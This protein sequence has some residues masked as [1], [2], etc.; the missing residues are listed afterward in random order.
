M[1]AVF[2]AAEKEAA[3]TKKV[4]NNLENAFSTFESETTQVVS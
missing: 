3:E 2:S 4:E 1:E